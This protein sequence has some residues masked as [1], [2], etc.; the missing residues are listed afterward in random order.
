VGR[1]SGGWAPK[2]SVTTRDAEPQAHNE[3]PH[4]CRS[5]AERLIQPMPA[6]RRLAED[7]RALAGLTIPYWCHAAWAVRLRR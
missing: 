2:L 1:R 5:D 3:N 4:T 7:V 6:C